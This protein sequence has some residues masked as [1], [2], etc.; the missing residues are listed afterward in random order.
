MEVHAPRP[1]VPRP[2]FDVREEVRGHVFQSSGCNCHHYLLSAAVT[3][4]RYQ[5]NV[6]I[7][8]HQ[9]LSPV[10][11]LSYVLNVALNV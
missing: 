6:I 3:L 1:Y 7:A 10:G 2:G 5:V 11:A 8:V 4:W 9:K